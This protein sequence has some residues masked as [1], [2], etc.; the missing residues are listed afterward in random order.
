MTL[1]SQLDPPCSRNT[2]AG[3]RGPQ[4]CPC[5]LA[6]LCCTLAP[7]AGSQSSWLANAFWAPSKSSDTFGCWFNLGW[8]HQWLLSA[9]F[10]DCQKRKGGSR[11]K[12]TVT[13]FLVHKSWNIPSC[14]KIE[15]LQFCLCKSET[16]T[17]SE[18]KV[19]C[20]HKQERQDIIFSSYRLNICLISPGVLTS[21]TK[22]TGN[23]RPPL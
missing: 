20:L 3:R 7:G 15:D 22:M 13:Q 5:A 17:Q 6:G 14:S 10:R 16:N 8:V 4:T 11:L 18:V 1:Q 2:D 9:T 21:H 23:L 19:S 12:T